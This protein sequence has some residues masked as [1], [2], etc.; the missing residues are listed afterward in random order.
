M[1]VMPDSVKV[2]A[3]F[4]V[5]GVGAFDVVNLGLQLVFH[6]GV[7]VFHRYK[8][9]VLRCIGSSH[10]AV[11]RAGKHRGT[12]GQP[13]KNHDEQQQSGNRNQNAYRVSCHKCR[14][15][16]CFLG[17]FLCRLAGVFRCVRCGGCTALFYYLCIVPLDF[18]LL[19]ETGKGIA[20]KLRVIVQ[21]F[22]IVKAGVCLCRCLF[23]LRRFAVGFQLV[24]AV[25]L[26]D[27]AGTVFSHTLGGFLGFMRPLH[28]GVI[29][30]H[31][32][33]LVMDKNPGFLCRTG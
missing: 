5:A 17:G 18:L 14:R 19:H 28:A 11:D 8:I 13:C 23:R 32:M 7:V 9:A 26:F 20:V 3:V 15:F 25:A 24:A 29:F 21:G 16:P 10:N 31:G 4:I 33:Y 27:L 2:V 1:G 22:V 30:L 6:S 12:R